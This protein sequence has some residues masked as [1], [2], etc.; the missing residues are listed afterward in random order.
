MPNGES[1]A[2]NDRSTSE[3]FEGELLFSDWD[4]LTSHE[5]AHFVAAIGLFVVSF[6]LAFDVMSPLPPALDDL[7]LG[8]LLLL[9][10]GVTAR[11][12]FLALTRK[13]HERVNGEPLELGRPPPRPLRVVVDAFES[14]IRIGAADDVYAADPDAEASSDAAPVDGEPVAASA[15]RE[16][17]V[18]RPFRP[19]QVEDDVGLVE[20]VRNAYE[21][22]EIYGFT[23]LFL[24]TFA[25]MGLS[26][27]VALPGFDYLAAVLAFLGF[28]VGT[29]SVVAI[30]VGTV[31][32]AQALRY[33]DEFQD[34]E[35]AWGERTFDRPFYEALPAVIALVERTF[36]PAI[37]LA[38]VAAPL[39][40]A[41][42]S[43]WTSVA[44]ALIL[45]L[46]V[47]GKRRRR[48][49]LTKRRMETLPDA[50]LDSS[51]DSDTD[52]VGVPYIVNANH[53]TYV[54][55]QDVVL[56]LG[57]GLV[58]VNVWLWTLLTLLGVQPGFGIV[59]TWFVLVPAAVA[60]YVAPRIE[61]SIVRNQAHEAARSGTDGDTLGDALDRM[62]TWD[63]T[64]PTAIWWALLVL[65]ALYF[66]LDLLQARPDLLRYLRL[67]PAG[68]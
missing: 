21:G 36:V 37:L 7:A 43:P 46:Y 18:D 17:A 34:D 6:L 67:D 66:A 41:N 42:F 57:M 26:V 31:L 53:H 47:A 52:P 12:Y 63:K 49:M 25:L 38:L 48:S 50:I 15:S 40:S 5:R 35:D 62:R 28:A 59:L 33:P 68:F 9:L 19:R 44:T 1:E 56:P 45:E 22:T 30:G 54:Y 65:L 24:L 60:Q 32:N 14:L 29:G 16:D 51:E 3:A 23:T 11:A 4:R 27:L 10:C 13:V 61:R 55:L 58:V 8:L 39:L 2:A 20:Q 64:V